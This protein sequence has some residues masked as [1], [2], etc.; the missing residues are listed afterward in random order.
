MSCLILQYCGT[1]CFLACLQGSSK[2][3]GSV[4]CMKQWALLN[5]LW[6]KQI[7]N[8]HSQAVTKCMRVSAV[9]KGT[10]AFNNTGTA[11]GSDS[12]RYQ[13]TMFCVEFRFI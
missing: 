1:V 11:L 3:R 8:K 5:F 4:M 10:I 12:T 6:Q 7:S 2:W 9:D 13:V